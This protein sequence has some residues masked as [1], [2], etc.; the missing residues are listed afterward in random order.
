[1][2]LMMLTNGCAGSCPPPKPPVTVVERC[3]TPPEN[4]PAI[5]PFPEQNADGTYTLSEDYAI[6]LATFVYFLID[7]IQVQY[8]KCGVAQ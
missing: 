2:S 3:M 4:V 7:Y 6:E 8:A 1:M 5:G